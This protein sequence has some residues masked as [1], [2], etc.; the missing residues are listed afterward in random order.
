MMMLGAAMLAIGLVRADDVQ[1][2][3][4]KEG[5]WEWHTVQIVDGEKSESSVK[6]CQTHEQEKAMQSANEA[7]KESCTSTTTR[8]SPGVYTAETNCKSGPLAGAKSTVKMVYHG[9][10]AYHAE[11]HVSQGSSEKV[12]I[13][14]SKY[15]GVCP[16]DMGPGD[17]VLPDGRKFN[18][19]GK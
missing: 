10:S 16:K 4:M 2:P 5:F 18:I 13:M 8:Q 14:D 15:L 19:S 9:D 3:P 11:A 1:L 17:A 7:V 6:V 12:T